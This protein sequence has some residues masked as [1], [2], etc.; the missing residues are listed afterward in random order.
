M[1]CSYCYQ[2]GYKSGLGWKKTSH[3]LSVSRCLLYR[4]STDLRNIPVNKG[5]VPKLWGYMILSL[6]LT[7]PDGGSIICLK[8][9]N[10][11]YTLIFP[12]N[13]IW[14]MR[15]THISHIHLQKSQYVGF[16]WA[17]TLSR[18]L[19]LCVQGQRQCARGSQL[20]H[21]QVLTSKWF[22]KKPVGKKLERGGQTFYSIQRWAIFFS[23]S[24]SLRLH[25]GAKFWSNCCYCSIHSNLHVL[26]TGEVAFKAH[27]QF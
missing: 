10:I 12:D 22:N 1:C 2:R 24:D 26:C 17:C 6:W 19:N 23:D 21:V 11:F 5:V 8:V 16:T 18:T 4:C 15:H 13:L 9:H 27:K 14:Q 25:I 20:L 3:K 7:S